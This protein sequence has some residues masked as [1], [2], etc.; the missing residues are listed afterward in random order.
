MLRSVNPIP[1]GPLVDASFVKEVVVEDQPAPAVEVRPAEPAQDTEER[2]TLLPSPLDALERVDR[3]LVTRK[4]LVRSVVLM[5]G[6]KNS[7]QVRG[8]DDR[9]LYTVEEI[10]RWWFLLYS[11]RPLHLRVLNA[12]GEEVIRM[13]RPCALTTRIFPC[14]L[15]S[16][17]VY[18]PPGALAGTVQQLY[19]PLKP[20]YAVKNADGDVVFEIEG[21]RITTC[22]FK[23]V[24]F[25]ISRPGGRRV[26]AASKLWQGVTHMMFVGPLSG[27]FSLSFE[28]S[29]S[30][31]EKALLLAASLLIDYVYYDA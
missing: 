14:Q 29:L 1:E 24:E 30:S 16:L 4:M 11:L 7:F 23:D 22:L 25:S 15:Q 8:A 18:T 3:L 12:E 6:K 19:S 5:T 26:G 10:N 21:P 13:V 28:K 2:L 17:R 31:Q 9:V 27:R 20:I